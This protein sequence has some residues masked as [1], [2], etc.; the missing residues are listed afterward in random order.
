LIAPLFKDNENYSVFG[1]V[2]SVM[3]VSSS[4]LLN[5]YKTYVEK[6]AKRSTEDLEKQIEWYETLYESFNSLCDRKLNKGIATIVSQKIYDSKE[7]LNEI[8][9]E[10][11]KDLSKFLSRKGYE[12]SGDDLYVSLYY[13]FDFNDDW[14]CVNSAQ[15]GLQITELMQDN[16]TFS[17]MVKNRTSD[18]ILY[19]SKQEAFENSRYIKDSDDVVYK[20]K[21]VGSIIGYKNHIIS[22]DKSYIDFIVFVTTYGRKFVDID[23]DQ[24]S[25]KD[26]YFKGL[27]NNLKKTIT[28]SFSKRIKIELQNLYIEEKKLKNNIP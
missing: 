11:D 22:G 13:R 16:S 2:L 25:D 14:K 8:L 12:F 6:T 27:K 20:G 17:Y 26:E 28:Q 9:K 1:I 5:A 23:E 3:V 10:L 7:Q 21:I 18:F 19:N 24:L 15:R 4:I